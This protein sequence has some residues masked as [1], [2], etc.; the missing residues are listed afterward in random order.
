MARILIVDDEP[1]I[2]L[3]TADWVEDLGHVPVGPVHA[4]RASLDL[5]ETTDIDGA[6]IDVS[7]GH[8]SGIPLA[9]LLAARGI[10]FVF[11]TGHAAADIG[12]SHLAASILAKPFEF[13]A[14]KEAVH[15]LTEGS[16][17]CNAAASV[18]VG[19]DNLQAPSRQ[20]SA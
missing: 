20:A 14:F 10:P 8:E 12:S 1:L 18:E 17:R 13:E 3:L 7:L 19:C 6:I 16:E 5:A 2:A 11:A 9:E 4:L 15:A